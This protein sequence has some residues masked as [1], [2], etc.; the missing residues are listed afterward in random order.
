[1][2]SSTGGAVRLQNTPEQWD[3]VPSLVERK[4][5]RASN[6]I[7]ATIR[8]EQ[9]DF[10]SRIVVKSEGKGVNISVYLDKPLPENL[11]G[12]AGFNLE[13]LPAAYFEKSYLVDGTPD[14]FPLYPSGN[15][16]VKPMSEKIEQFAGHSTLDDR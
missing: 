14:I 5:D 9:L 16:S 2:R 3:L 15:T 11:E 13:F 7:E 12:K 8:Y 1:M 10:T 6:T 4:V